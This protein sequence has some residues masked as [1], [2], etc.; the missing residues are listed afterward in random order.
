MCVCNDFFFAISQQIDSAL[1]L[2]VDYLSK[3]ASSAQSMYTMAVCAYALQITDTTLQSKLQV[4]TKIKGEAL[5]K[6]SSKSM[7]LSSSELLCVLL[8]SCATV[9]SMLTGKIDIPMNL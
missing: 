2:A 3:Q 9:K 6:G 1:G 7:L 8:S 5:T 4:M